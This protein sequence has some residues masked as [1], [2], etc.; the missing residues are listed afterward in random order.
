MTRRDP[1][2][3][4]LWTSRETA[5]FLAIPL[6]TLYQFNHSGLGPQF[7]RIGK[8]CRYDPRDVLVW[9]EQRRSKGT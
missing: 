6:A 3:D 8:H 9:L 4:H 1:L 2:P 5:A 7:F